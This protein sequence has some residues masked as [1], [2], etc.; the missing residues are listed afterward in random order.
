MFPVDAK[1]LIVDDSQF[2]RKAL[3]DS[4]RSLKFWKILEA[5]DAKTAQ[6][7]LTEPEQQKDPVHL[8][9]SD[10]HMPEMNGLELLRWVR[11]QEKYQALP[12]IILTTAQEK[13]GILEAGKLGVSHYMI[14]PFD[15]ATLRDRMTSTWDK[16]GQKFF[17]NNPKT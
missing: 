6:D 14:K 4:L 7:L 3:K 9:I 1:I 10:L 15:T 2:S 17:A 8:L 16:H 11:T 13:N 12:V 5:A